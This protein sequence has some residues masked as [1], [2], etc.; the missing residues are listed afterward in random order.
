[1]PLDPNVN[2]KSLEAGA[3]SRNLE[4][5]RL[6]QRLDEVINFIRS[7]AITRDFFEGYSLSEAIQ[8]RL[9][10]IGGE[11]Q[12][13]TQGIRGVPTLLAEL[14]KLETDGLQ[15]ITAARDVKSVKT[16]SNQDAAIDPE[17]LDNA[18]VLIVES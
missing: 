2:K 6:A 13:F 1:M 10:F 12:E 11:G 9:D 17:Q 16:A 7:T 4:A 18:D 5:R 14:D 15:A 8:E 3:V